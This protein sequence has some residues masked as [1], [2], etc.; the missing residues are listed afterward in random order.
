MQQAA[1]SPATG[2]PAG[3]HET[4]PREGAKPRVAIV[5]EHPIQYHSPFFRYLADDGR[6][7]ITVLYLCDRGIG[8]PF[9]NSTGVTIQYPQSILEGYRWKA[10]PNRSPIQNRI[11]F[12]D[13]CDTAVYREIIDGGFDAVYVFGYTYASHWV[14][15]AACIRAGIPI[16]FRGESE[17][18]F[19][20]PWATRLIKR[21]LLTPLFSRIGAFLYIGS[22]N[23]EFYLDYGVP[24][25]KLFSVPYGCDNE[26]FQATPET[27][28]EWRAELRAKYGFRDDTVVFLF[29]SQHR[30][31]KRPCDA[32]E[33]FCRIPPE[34]NAV[35]LMLGDGPLRPDAE[36]VYRA[37]GAGRRV[38]FAGMVKF[39]EMRKYFAA[40][41]VLVAPSIEPIGGQLAEGTAAGMAMISSD[42]C[43]GWRDLV[44]PGINGLVHRAGS[45]V[46]L[47][48]CMRSLAEHPEVVATMR[49][50]TLARSEA[51]SFRRMAE[52]FVQ[53]VH[54]VLDGSRRAPQRD[55]AARSG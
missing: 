50:E 13:Q 42:L 48:A 32:V 1:P 18:V 10:L 3:A 2:T 31:M 29:A 55:G 44:E 33:A 11:I 39:D 15:F 9:K 20:R 53:A 22:Y 16:L 54:Y 46:G 24:E 21:V 36:A 14:A 17:A 5:I 27:R 8:G 47:T 12:L 35:L 45:I 49:R 25:E 37:Q 4:V 51:V 30:A 38:I 19:P 7:D 23:R 26:S 34:A 40:S 41:D 52:G 43:I 28:A 6:L